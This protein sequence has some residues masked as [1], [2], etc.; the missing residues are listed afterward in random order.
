MSNIFNDAQ[1]RFL[2]DEFQR[3]RR[4]GEKRPP[5][6]DSLRL[7]FPISRLGDS[8]ISSQEVGRWFANRSKQEDGQPRAKAKTPEQLAILEESFARDPYPDFNERARLVLATLLTKSQV[9]AWLG[10]QRQ[11]RPEE[12]Y[13]AGYPPGTPLPGFEKSEQGTRTF[14]KE[15]EAE[16]KRL[17]QEEHAALQEGNDEYL[18]A[19]DEEMA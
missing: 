18:A 19:E 9:D 13:A 7:R 5:K 16:R 8:L 4:R 10:R 1:L 3:S 12:V 2:E 6:R 11:R 14:W 15:I 17:E